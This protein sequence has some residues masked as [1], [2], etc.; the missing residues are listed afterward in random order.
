MHAPRAR[1]YD[2]STTSYASCPVC[3]AGVSVEPGESVPNHQ[4]TG[5]SRIC[6]GSGQTAI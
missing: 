3:G 4:E 6:S 2:L 5:T 1:R